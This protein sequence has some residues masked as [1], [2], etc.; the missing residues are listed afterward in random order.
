MTAGIAS[1]KQALQM[2]EYLKQDNM[3]G[4]EIPFA[5]L[6]RKDA[7][8]VPQGQYW[9]GGVW[10]PTAYA[11]LKGLTSYGYHKEAQ[12]L[13]NKLLSHI[14]KTYQEYE[15]HTIWECYAPD[16]CAPSTQTDNETIVRPDFCGWS[17]L[18]PISI[19]IEYV[20]GFHTIDAFEKIVQWEKPN[21]INGKIGVKNL[22][23]GEVVTDI[24]AEGAI[25]NVQSNLPYTLVVNG[26]AFPIAIGNNVINLV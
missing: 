17:A 20:L 5:S 7:D 13:A 25:C 14:W 24:V 9:R 16:F 12:E 8:F 2:L 10:L 19:F 6:A 18:G 11:T 21:N 4:G 22:R 15:P 26:K 3:F 1:E 23:F